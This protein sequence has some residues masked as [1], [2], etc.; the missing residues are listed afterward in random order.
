MPKT[1]SSENPSGEVSIAFWTAFTGQKKG[2]PSSFMDD[3]YLNTGIILLLLPP[4]PVQSKI[5]LISRIFI[6][7]GVPFVFVN[8]LDGK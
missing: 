4:S 2:F 7:K 3:Q 1:L 6:K 5:V 8:S